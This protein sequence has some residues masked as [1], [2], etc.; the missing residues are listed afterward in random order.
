MTRRP[1]T[2]S[3]LEAS[4]PIMDLYGLALKE[5]NAKKPAYEMHKWWA[6]RLGINFRF[7]LVA[8]M[9]EVCNRKKVISELYARHREPDLVICDPFMG[10]GTSLVEA[11]KMAMRTIGIDI[12]PVAWFVTKKELDSFDEMKFLDAVRL[13]ESRLRDKLKKYYQTRLEDGTFV[14]VVYYF[15]VDYPACPS[16]RRKF[17]AHPTFELARNERKKNRVVF[18]KSCHSV[19]VIDFDQKSFRCACCGSSTSLSRAPVKHG[20]YTCPHCGSEGKLKG[21]AGPGRP[22]AKKLFAVEYWDPKKKARKYTA[23][24]SFDSKLFREVCREFNSLKGKLPFPREAIPTMSRSDNRPVSFGYSHYSSLFNERQLL[25]L[26]L[27]YE[28]ILEVKD[29]NTREYLLLALSDSLACN[30]MLCAYAF[31][32]RKLTP[33]FG[34]HS[35][36]HVSRP[37][38]GNVWGAPEG[39]GSFRRCLEKVVKGKGYCKN[40]FEYKYKPTGEPIRVYT[41]EKI[42]GKV[43]DNYSEWA[44]GQANCLLVNRSAEDLGFISDSSVDMVLTDPPYFNNLSYS[45]LSDFYWVWF[46]RGIAKPR[47]HWRGTTSPYKQA[48]Y[49]SRLTNSQMSRY[50]TGLSRVFAECGRILKK[51]GRLVFTY[52][53]KDRRAWMSLAAGLLAGGFYVINVFPMLSEGRSGFH[54]S[55]GN[56]KWDSVFVCS[57]RKGSPR[58]KLFGRNLCIKKALANADKWETRLHGASPTKFNGVDR[59]SLVYASLVAEFTRNGGTVDEIGE[60]F[61]VLISTPNRPSIRN[62]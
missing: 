42:E 2:S 48:L 26:S 22:I 3:V 51:D 25:A 39:R 24:G 33:L 23:A 34:L 17:E 11:S 13:I 53:H 55:N 32:Y 29:S 54:T 21:L 50:T 41:G 46:K 62:E 49:V 58:L 40:A 60:F 9:L 14:D 4:P 44:A 47:S 20:R 10:G 7:L 59:Q 30:N 28:A 5:G 16:C 19:R 45:E 31:G 6:R 38:E 61:D 56:I 57:K 12:D 52:H 27:I 35:Y 36:R 15:W 8:S 43:T 18:C 37:V 1:P